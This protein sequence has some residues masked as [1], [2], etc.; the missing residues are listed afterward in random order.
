MTKGGIHAFTKSLSVQLIDRGSASTPSRRAPVWTPLNPADRPPQEVAKFG[1]GTAMGRAAQ[2]EEI[3]P[4]FV[5]MAAPSCSLR[6]RR[7]S[8]DRRRLW[9]SLRLGLRAGMGH[10][11]DAPSPSRGLLDSRKRVAPRAGQRPTG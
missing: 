7:D 6:H 1:A 5:F 10:D 11:A 4:A 2:P 8:A 9:M 3:A